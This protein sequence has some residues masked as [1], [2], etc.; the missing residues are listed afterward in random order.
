M[1]KK[2]KIVFIVVVIFMIILSILLIG[3]SI[4][5]TCDSY[6]NLFTV[7]TG[8]LGFIPATILGALAIFQNIIYENRQ[9]INEK[10]K[11]E[12]VICLI[13]GILEQNKARLDLIIDEKIFEVCKGSYYRINCLDN[14]DKYIISGIEIS[15]EPF[16][17]LVEYNKNLNLLNLHI[18][19]YNKAINM[20]IERDLK[21]YK[22]I[23]IDEA[24]NLVNLHTKI[25]V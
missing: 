25:K 1:N 4:K 21:E 9:T 3:L 12:N 17:T 2:C 5:Y 22:T 13:K 14:L 20:K 24:K 19:M 16:K 15:N 10:K 7:I 8:V 23:I 11:L 6:S 18:E